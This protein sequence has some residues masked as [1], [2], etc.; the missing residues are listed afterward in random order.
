MKKQKINQ[1]KVKCLRQITK[2]KEIFR[3]SNGHI[4]PYFKTKV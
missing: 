3:N 4:F 1:Q 2:A